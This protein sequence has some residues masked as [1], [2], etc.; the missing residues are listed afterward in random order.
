MR[1][2]EQRHVP[3]RRMQSGRQTP[4]QMHRSALLTLF[5]AS[6]CSIGLQPA[7]GGLV[8]PSF[9]APIAG[10]GSSN[11]DASRRIPPQRI[12]DRPHRHCVRQ[13]HG[14]SENDRNADV[15]LS[16]EIIQAAEQ[17]L[18][19]EI[20]A[21]RQRRPVL[22]LS[23]GSSGDAD[24]SL[25]DAVSAGMEDDKSTISDGADA[26]SENLEEDLDNWKDGVVWIE[27]KTALVGLS[28]LTDDEEKGN[29]FLSGCP[30]LARL[31]TEDTI[32]SAQEAIESMGMAPSA[33][34]Q[35]PILLSYPSHLYA[36]AIE[37]L[38]NMMML[39]EPT[40]VSLCKMNPGLLI[41]GL[42]GYIQE[43]SVKNA[44]GSAGDALYGVSRSVANDVGKTMRG[45][46]AGPKGL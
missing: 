15:V 41:G 14:T 33:L 31:P 26:E 11:I 28:V 23:G 21:E 29:A 2:T 34:E 45:V 5:V 37:F 16:D 46:K 25:S 35:N 13:L 17:K 10:G 30:Q 20:A 24:L 39:P 4:T 27:T 12:W 6:V 43:Q 9:L 32:A 8:H 42:D 3:Q 40:I 36:G 18:S 19:W 22:D 44:L 38:S 7:H 1:S